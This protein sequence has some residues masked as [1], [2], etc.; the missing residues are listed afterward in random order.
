MVLNY[1]YPHPFRLES[2]ATLPA[3]D[4]AYHTFGRRNPDGSNVIWV[5][6]ALTANSDVADWWPNTVVPGGFLDP[7]KYF[8]VCANIVGSHYGT[9]GPLSVNP[10]TGRPWFDSF[11]EITVRDMVNAHRLLAEHLGIRRVR[12]LI[13]SSLG[14]FQCM[15]WA[16][17]DPDFA[18]KVA[19][20]ATSAVSSPWAAAF[21]ESQRMAIEADPTYG[22][23]D[24]DAGRH[25]L[26][27][28]RSIALLSYRGAPAYNL[29]QAD[30]GASTD[31]D[32]MFRRRVHSYQ[33]HQGEKLSARFNAY[34]YH[35][36][37]RAV[38]AHDIAR[39]RAASVEEAL[40]AFKPK[41]LVIGITSDI[42][43]T[44][45]D[46]RRLAD[47]I[48]GAQLETIESNFGHDGFLV[49]HKQLN[50]IICNFLSK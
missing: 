23:P 8:I 40:K 31:P 1:H 30:R 34:S 19:L 12:L 16:L 5:C 9:T 49:E 33:R 10:E 38:D 50:T 3:L 11:P 18:E 13:G 42:L 43:F 35:R 17:I 39:N 48:P 47:N 22:Q 2:G 26:E 24:P 32:N 37:S 44:L 14:G 36:L 7:E 4:I 46:A 29:T 21:N 25:G 45:D 41:A 15:E 20:V 28:A 6:H 27:A